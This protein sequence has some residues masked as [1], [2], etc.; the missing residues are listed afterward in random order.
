MLSRLLKYEFKATGRMFLP[1]YA[2][3]VIWAVITRIFSGITNHNVLSG[4]ATAG[5][6]IAALIEG[7]F[8]MIMVLLI[9]GIFVATFIITIHRFYKNMVTDEGYLMFTMPVKVTSHINSKLIAAFVWNVLSIVVAGIAVLILI[10]YKDIW[11]YFSFKTLIDSLQKATEGKMGFVILEFS[12]L[13]IA[14]LAS[15]IL[16][17]YACIAIG[18]LFQ[19]HKIVMAIVAYLVIQFVIDVLGSIGMLILSFNMEGTYMEGIQGFQFMINSVSVFCIIIGAAFYVIT[20]VIFN[21]R[22]NLE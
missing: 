17:L 3:I 13:C 15:S 4:T 12:V 22:L 10:S 18:H 19:K 14:G 21:N 2:A 8:M 5:N 11:K 16:M 6:R 1:C 7:V 20:Q 9:F